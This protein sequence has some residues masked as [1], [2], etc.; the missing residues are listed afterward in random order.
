MF[1]CRR[2]PRNLTSKTTPNLQLQRYQ[3]FDKSASCWHWVISYN[4]A[5]FASLNIGSQTFTTKC[6]VGLRRVRLS[7]NLADTIRLGRNLLEAATLRLG[8]FA[9]FVFSKKCPCQVCQQGEVHAEIGYLHAL[10]A[11]ALHF[12]K[13]QP[14]KLKERQFLILSKHII[15]PFPARNR[16]V[17][18]HSHILS[19]YTLDGPF[20]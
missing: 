13:I 5:T 8:G 1:L 18:I 14:G 3:F 20:N 11:K 12:V 19:I 10:P 7:T 4:S 17:L 16:T 2:M 6:R 9:L 15:C